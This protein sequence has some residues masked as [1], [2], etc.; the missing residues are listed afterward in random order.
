MKDN[1]QIRSWVINL[2]L[3]LLLV[4]ALGAQKPRMFGDDFSQDP[5]CEM[6][7]K[8][9]E[10]VFR[11]ALEGNH[12]VF[13]VGRLGTGDSTKMSWRRLSVIESR[14]AALSAK[15]PVIVAEGRPNFDAKGA[16]E[17]WLSGKPRAVVRFEKNQ[18]FCIDTPEA[19]ET[20][21]RKAN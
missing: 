4:S 6:T 11:E 20:G 14:L 9:V 17:F 3:V 10:D 15:L 13:V 5:G 8:V 1:V 16:L 7:A 18:P 12:T 2:L 21:R 19:R